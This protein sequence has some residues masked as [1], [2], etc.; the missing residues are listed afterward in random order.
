MGL[1]VHAWDFAQATGQEPPRMDGLSSYVL[2]LAKDSRIGG[3]TT[4]LRMP[5]A[6]WANWSSHGAVAASNSSVRATMCS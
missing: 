1:L 6:Q 3:S 5:V 2:G 4:D